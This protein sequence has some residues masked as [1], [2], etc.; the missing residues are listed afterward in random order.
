MIN[1]VLRAEV[2]TNKGMEIFSEE[3][4]QA[5]SKFG[6]SSKQHHVQQVDVVVLD[7][8][9]VA[10]FTTAV[11][12]RLD[13]AKRGPSWD[14]VYN[15]VKKKFG[16]LIQGSKDDGTSVDA[17][18]Q[19]QDGGDS[20]SGSPQTRSAG[21]KTKLYVYGE[22]GGAV[23]GFLRA[24]E[25][26]VKEKF[27]KQEYNERSLPDMTEGQ[28]QQIQTLA[29]QHDV[30]IQLDK[31]LGRYTLHGN[32]KSVARAHKDITEVAR[33]A[34][35]HQQER[36]KEA[37]VASLVQ[38][39]FL[40]RVSTGT[41]LKAYDKRENGKIERAFLSKEKT[42]ELV[43]ADGNVYVVDFDLMV[44]YPKGDQSE[45]E[46]VQVVRKLKGPDNS[47]SISLP[48]T[49]AKHHNDE[50]VMVVP[51]KRSDAEYLAVQRD[52]KASIGPTPVT[53][54]SID[55]VQN[56]MLYQQYWVKKQHMDRQNGPG[57]PNEK[58]LW[59]GTANDAI[60]N[61]NNHGF[62]RSY[63]GKNAT[64]YGDGVYFALESSYSTQKT[65]SPPDSSGNRY[66]YQCRVLTGH[67]TEGKAKMR[68]LPSR[69]GTVMYDSA[70][71][72]L[73]QPAMYIIFNDT[74][75]YPEYLIT[76]K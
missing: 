44:E 46:C 76:F 6:N 14:K 71:D 53:I 2:G 1:T 50:P 73:K 26:L 32:A 62:N 5:V 29:G 28:I 49:W 7:G 37:I 67:P 33:E 3:L 27:I 4:V 51:L 42:A 15:A 24:F 25:E 10:P 40:E 22:S 12:A 48:L 58:L 61:I 45:D 39:G 75:A 36:E 64:A 38:W 47:D 69:I 18:M 65:Y 63:C 41:E 59:H 56:R 11:Q 20:Q 34:D 54:L 13:K 57:F 8:L 21:E 35:R 60:Q 43:D 17:D 31:T 70:T 74:Q 9:L 72:D 30:K 19:A 52:L 66:L 55:R 16:Q 23:M 68:F